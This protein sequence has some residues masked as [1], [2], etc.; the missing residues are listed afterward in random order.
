MCSNKEKQRWKPYTTE[1]W[2]N[3]AKEKYPQFN[4]NKVVYKDKNTK[5][6]IICEKH[7]E[8]LVRPNRF[9]NG[10]ETCQECLNEERRK[11]KYEKFKEQAKIVHNNFYI[12]LDNIDYK[13]ITTKIPIECPIHGIFEQAPNNHLNGHGCPK[14]GNEIVYSTR[15]KTEEQFLEDCRN[16]HGE[17]YDYSETKYI[18]DR[19]SIEII[20]SK[21]GSFF[22][23]PHA[24]LSGQ[25][26]PKCGKE[27][28]KLKMRKPFSKIV[29]DARLIHGDKYEYDESSYIST[30]KPMNITCPI[31]G[32]FQQ[33]PFNHIIGKH[34]CPKCNMSH[35][36]RETMAFLERNNIKYEYQKKFDWLGKQSLDFYLTDYNAAIEC[37]G[38]QHFE[39]DKFYKNIEIVQERDKRKKILCNENKVKVIYYYKAKY[40]KYMDFNSDIIINN[41]NDLL[42]LLKR[43]L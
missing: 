19:T 13:N 8:F 40:N 38:S 43:N 7:G 23:A 4:Y 41:L 25:G 27:S 17:K 34:G 3:I 20:C 22:M 16:V 32:V 5:I 21:H 31:H 10:Q 12:Y 15:R 42:V 6:C 18:N 39:K 26:C 1:E 29:E 24:H 11:W 30:M 14:C 35:L 2:V 9:L 33:S 37:Q 28:M 36:E